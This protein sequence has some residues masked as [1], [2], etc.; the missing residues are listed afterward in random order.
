MCMRKQW[1]RMHMHMHHCCTNLDSYTYMIMEPRDSS[2][3]V[4]MHA[5][6]HGLSH[7]HEFVIGEVLLLVGKIDV[8]RPTAVRPLKFHQAVASYVSRIDA[9]ARGDTSGCVRGSCYACAYK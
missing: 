9:A 1:I 2:E 8:K 6:V 7:L 5:H 4:R 3:I